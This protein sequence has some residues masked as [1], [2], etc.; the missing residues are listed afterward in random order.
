MPYFQTHLFPQ[1]SWTY[2]AR[3]HLLELAFLAPHTLAFPCSVVWSYF[4]DH[5]IDILS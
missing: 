1:T 2:A 3:S 5:V 4:P